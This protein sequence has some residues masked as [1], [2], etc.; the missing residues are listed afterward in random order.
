[1]TDSNDIFNYLAVLFSIILGLAVTEILQGFRRILLLRRRIIAYWPAILWG[2]ILLVVCAQS[3]WALFGLHKEREWTFGMYGI[4]LT[5][6]ALLYLVAGLSL[7]GAD[8]ESAFDMRRAYFENARPFF[9]LLV[10]MI[11]ASLVKDLIFSGHLPDPANMVFHGFF[12]LA[13]LIAAVTR[14]DR[15]HKINAPLVALLIGVYVIMLF[16]RID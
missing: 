1:M 6:T 11:G 8:E 3:W 2:F 16:N 14:N 9:V 4:V 15:F 12:A 7:A 10:A 13:G 5:Q